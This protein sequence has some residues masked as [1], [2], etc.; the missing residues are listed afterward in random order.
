MKKYFVAFILLI[1]VLYSFSFS[2]TFETKVVGD[3]RDYIQTFNLYLSQIE[4]TGSIESVP[5]NNVEQAVYT[6]VSEFEPAAYYRWIRMRSYQIP[7]G[8][9]G[10]FQTIDMWYIAQ[11]IYQRYKTNDEVENVALAGFLVYAIDNLYGKNVSQTDFPYFTTFNQAVF[12]LG[13]KVQNAAADLTKAY[14]QKSLGSPGTPVGNYAYRQ[15]DPKSF[16]ISALQK[17]YK[18][19]PEYILNVVNSYDFN[20]QPVQN[21]SMN[22]YISDLVF[23]SLDQNA[24]NSA[25]GD[26]KNKLSQSADSSVK[27]L[28][29]LLSSGQSTKTAVENMLKGFSSSIIVQEMLAANTVKNPVSKNFNA[30]IFNLENKLAAESETPT[31][32]I[33]WRWIIYAVALIFAFVYKRKI[34]GYVMLAILVFESLVLIFGIDPMLSRLDSTLYGFLI[35]TVAFLSFLSFL[36]IGKIKNLFQII[37]MVLVGVLFLIVIF[38]PLYSN[39]EYTRMSN[40]QNFLKSPYLGIYENELY[41][42]NGIITYDLQNI[43]SDLSALRSDTYN[44]ANQTISFYLTTLK[45]SGALKSI[46]EYPNSLLVNVDRNSSYFGFS[47]LGNSQDSI[48]V[49]RDRAQAAIDDIQN[50][51]NSVYRNENALS[52][53]LNGVYTFAAPQLRNDIRK[54]LESQISSSNLTEISTQL[55]N[56]VNKANSIEERAPNIQFFQTPDGSKVFILISML[57]ISVTFFRKNWMY[58]FV[59]SLLTIL[60]SVMI[61]YQKVLEIFVEYGFPT[62]S[63]TLLKGEGP[64]L[65]I[66]ILIIAVSIFVAF[67]ALYTRFKLIKEGKT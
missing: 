14:F 40:N 25:F 20:F 64:N 51:L 67:E 27:T 58:R 28:K 62:Y 44:F 52:S 57:L 32:P 6:I 35:V 16:I 47:N 2:S 22:S 65:F 59:I 26:L 17:S 12:D 45:K 38:L 66:L 18:N 50:R 3:Y 46:V 63:H 13:T 33:E 55:I 11:N 19:V 15:I 53:T 4:K 8:A 41:G 54:N 39:L 29:I 60:G 61:F 56:I 30:K 36:S 23:Q 49:V 24:I 9:M 43:S 21:P 34:V 31:S 42:Q 1:L 37:S 5:S 48:K 10:N 7:P